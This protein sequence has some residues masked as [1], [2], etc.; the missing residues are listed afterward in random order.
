VLR[1]WIDSL[2]PGEGGWLGALGDPQIGRAPQLIHEQ[3]DR[4]W[5]L[6]ELGRRVGLGRSAFSARFSKLVG[7][8]MNRYL[9]AHRME[10]AASVLE[11]TDEAVSEVA[12]RVGYQTASAFS[13]LFHR[14]HDMSPGRYR[15]ARRRRDRVD[16]YASTSSKGE[17]FVHGRRSRPVSRVQQQYG[18]SPAQSSH[19]LSVFGLTKV[20]LAGPGQPTD[21]KDQ[22]PVS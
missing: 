21:L 1:S 11:S 5:T 13:K 3:P 22:G 19:R 8:P 20:N 2:R 15:A 18:V 6:Q 12:A 10:E 9:I 7:E 17:A 16:S 4:S 14:H